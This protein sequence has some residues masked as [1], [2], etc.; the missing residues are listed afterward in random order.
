MNCSVALCFGAAGDWLRRR[1]GVWRWQQRVT[2]SLF[3]ALGLRL[4]LVER[5]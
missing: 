1:P 4:A 3:V 2:G 5:G